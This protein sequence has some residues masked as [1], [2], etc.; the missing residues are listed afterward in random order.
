MIGIGEGRKIGNNKGM[1]KK[2]ERERNKIKDNFV[3]LRDDDVSAKNK[4]ENAGVNTIF[5]FEIVF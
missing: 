5:G 3:T 4:F 2:K 1:G